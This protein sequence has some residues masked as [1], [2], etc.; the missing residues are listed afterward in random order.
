MRVRRQP[1]GSNLVHLP[2]FNYRA[3]TWEHTGR[4]CRPHPGVTLD[5]L[6][7]KDLIH[8][9]HKYRAVALQR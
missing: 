5:G 8:E 2:A 6:K 3:G 7:I 1:I 4:S 9:G